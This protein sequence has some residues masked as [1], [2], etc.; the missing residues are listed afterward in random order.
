[1]SRLYKYINHTCMTHVNYI[2]CFLPCYCFVVLYLH[3]Y[4]YSLSL[5]LTRSFFIV[6]FSISLSCTCND[7]YIGQHYLPQENQ[8]E[9]TVPYSYRF[10]T[11][12]T[13]NKTP[14]YR[15]IFLFSGLYLEYYSSYHHFESLD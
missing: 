8:A 15:R 2:C 4:M 5:S 9:N 13:S 6:L 7:R 12:G 10:T 1:M 14:Y 11:Y 3:V